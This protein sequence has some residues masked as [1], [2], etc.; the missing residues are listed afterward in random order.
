MELRPHLDPSTFQR[1]SMLIFSRCHTLEKFSI[2]GRHDLTAD[3]IAPLEQHCTS[4]KGP[5]ATR[6]IPHLYAHMY[7]ESSAC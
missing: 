5:M 1:R 7:F 3:D 6:N 4:P 2:G